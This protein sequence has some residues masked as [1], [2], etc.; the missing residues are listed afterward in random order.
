[1]TGFFDPVPKAGQFKRV[2]LCYLEVAEE[3][4][5]CTVPLVALVP[6]FAPFIS[7]HLGG[8]CQQ[9]RE[10]AN[11]G[12]LNRII[13]LGRKSVRVESRTVG[14]DIEEKFAAVCY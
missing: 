8:L 6:K 13:K 1:M 10:L 7:K 5:S 2:T 12:P 11:M 9:L 4:E 3:S 14:M